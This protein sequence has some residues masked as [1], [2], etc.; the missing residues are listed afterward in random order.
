MHRL[1]DKI[2]EMAE[3]MRLAADID[4]NNSNCAEEKLAHYKKENEACDLCDRFE[5]EIPPRRTYP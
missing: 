5:D 2:S 1:A 3:V 4:E